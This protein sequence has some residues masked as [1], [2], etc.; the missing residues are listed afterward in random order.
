MNFLDE[1]QPFNL[2]FKAAGPPG[3]QGR[4]GSMAAWAARTTAQQEKRKPLPLFL[5]RRGTFVSNLAKYCLFLTIV[6]PD[7]QEQH[8]KV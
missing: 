4:L 1:Q 7:L 6:Q 2:A 3:Q 8:T 5:R